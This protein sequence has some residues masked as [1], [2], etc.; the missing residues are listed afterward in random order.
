MPMSF[1][2]RALLGATAA[3]CVPGLHAQTRRIDLQGHRGARGLRPENT[4]EAMA[5]AMQLGVST[6]EMDV[7]AT[8]DEVLVLGHDRRLNPDITRG[9]DGQFLSGEGP[10]V[11]RLRFTELQAFD[12]GRIRPGSAYA[13]QF[14]DQQPVDGA[15]MPRLSEVLQ[16]AQADGPAGLR[17]SIELKSSPLEPTLTPAPER[18]AELLLQAIEAHDWAA[19]CTVQCFDWRVLQAVQR[20]RPGLATAY[21]TAQLPSLNNLQIGAAQ[22]SPWTAGFD[23]A[24]HGSVPRMVAAAGGTHWSSFWRELDAAQVREAHALGLQVLAW[25][26]NQVPDMERVLDLG[27]DGLIT[28]RPDRAIAL[29]RARGWRW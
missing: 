5:L 3:V 16:R 6:L 25:T 22:A 29:L 8:A 9:P 15:R 19:R 23:H 17:L 26:V 14:A 13:Q 2:R 7:V 28:D 4:L 24:R 20:L 18:F 11:H 12:V 21:L 10:A 1:S 27:V